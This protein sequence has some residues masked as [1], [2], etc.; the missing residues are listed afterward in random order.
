MGA[1]EIIA[2]LRDNKSNIEKYGVDR[3]GL[4]GSY[5][6]NEQSDGSDVDILVRF[7]KG[8]KTF[9]NYMGLKFYLE[10]LLGKK[11]DLVITEN[12]KIELKDEILGSVKYA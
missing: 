2:A 8:C 9:D 1:E 10:D 11:V 3:I 5:S 12:I 7:K 6:R 4:F